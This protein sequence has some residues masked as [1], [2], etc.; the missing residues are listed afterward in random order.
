MYRSPSVSGPESTK[1]ISKIIEDTVESER[2]EAIFVGDFNYPEIDWDRSVSRAGPNHY[3][4][5]FLQASQGNLLSHYVSQSTCF[6]RG[7]TASTLDLILA[8]EEDMVGDLEYLAPVGRSDHAVLS[9][10]IQY[11]C[12]IEA[13]S[14]SSRRNGRLSKSQ[15][16]A[17]S[18]R[19]E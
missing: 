9:F 18:D 5:T 11:Y 1:E 13:S 8:T 19:L 17:Q 7:Q 2:S 6:R 10:R 16:N 15:I 3:S 12:V 4:S 14:P